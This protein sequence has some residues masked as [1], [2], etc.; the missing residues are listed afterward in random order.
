[1]YLD[2]VFPGSRTDKIFNHIVHLAIQ[3]HKLTEPLKVDDF[4]TRE[5]PEKER[6]QD[7][8]SAGA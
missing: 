5:W 8:G 7:S 2:V 6:R 4:K 3:V 1:M